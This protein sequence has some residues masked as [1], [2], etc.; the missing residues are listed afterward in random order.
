M[1]TNMMSPR[2]A[3]NVLEIATRAENVGRLSRRDYVNIEAALVALDA[4]LPKEEAPKP[5]EEKPAA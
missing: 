2:A 5:P 3:L 1:N 4:V